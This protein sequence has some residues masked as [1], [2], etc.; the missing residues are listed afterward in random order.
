MRYFN[1]ILR[2]LDSAQSP[3]NPEEPNKK[4]SSNFFMRL[5]LFPKITWRLS[6]PKS[7]S[8]HLSLAWFSSL[9]KR[10]HI[11]LDAF[12]TEITSWEAWFK[13]K[14]NHK[15]ILN[16]VNFGSCLLESV[17]A[18]KTAETVEITLSFL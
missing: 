15:K 5:L 4:Q 17:E 7:T 1:M 18:E 9:E 8:N 10:Y 3:S 2:D 11:T 6:D 12:K 14:E 16:L 13:S